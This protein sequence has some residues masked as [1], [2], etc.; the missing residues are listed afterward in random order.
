MGAAPC[1]LELQ[2]YARTRR[3]HA[4]P[5]A[6]YSWAKASSKTLRILRSAHAWM[7]ASPKSGLTKAWLG[8]RA[9]TLTSES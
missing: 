6:G 8:Q 3:Q 5:R 4:A 9:A 1:P 7:S 2:A